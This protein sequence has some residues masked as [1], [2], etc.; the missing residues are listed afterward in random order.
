MVTDV[1]DSAGLTIVNSVEFSL[2][3]LWDT[4]KLLRTVGCWSRDSGML[5]GAAAVAALAR[6]TSGRDQIAPVPGL[7]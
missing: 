6:R 5:P 1:A 3:K 4:S 7:L 2:G